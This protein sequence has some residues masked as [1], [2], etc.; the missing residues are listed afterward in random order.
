MK[1]RDELEVLLNEEFDS[2]IKPMSS[3]LKS[4]PIT[5]KRSL[6]FKVMIPRVLAP[7]C[8]ITL[9]ITLSIIALSTSNK[10]VDNECYVIDVNPSIAVISEDDIVVGV[11]SINQDGDLILL[12]LNLDEVIGK[13]KSE[14]AQI[15]VDEY[16]RLGYF[17][18]HNKINISTV[19]SN[20]SYLEDGMMNYLCNKGYMVA[21]LSDEISLDNYN[22]KNNTNIKSIDEFEKYIHELSVLECEK[23][24]NNTSIS[25]SD[26]TDDFTYEYLRNN[27]MKLIEDEK[28]NIIT[29]IV[30][31]TE[32]QTSYSKLLLDPTV[33]GL[34]KDYWHL[35]DKYDNLSKTTQDKLD[36]ITELIE[37]YYLYT[38]VKISSVSDLVDFE[39]IISTF[40][41]KLEKL[42]SLLEELNAVNMAESFE[43]II[44]E[45]NDFVEAI[46]LEKYLIL[47]D[48]KVEFVEFVKS[49]HNDM[50]IELLSDN[51]KLYN[52]QRKTITIEEYQNFLNSFNKN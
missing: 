43:K 49:L 19:N 34:V 18:S 1:K 21:V 14:V 44:S 32:I 17:N 41:T 22:E 12:G 47:P 13:S 9:M 40:Q 3:K 48:T 24:L 35:L 37:L 50:R 52:H 26:I 25:D 6:K 7:V 8:V 2:R 16:M 45:I 27:L 38:G 51:E 42:K 4:Y 46:N 36:G 30:T 5:K 10:P 23:V 39:E 29:S 15:I 11:K 20:D 31:L 33:E 28:N